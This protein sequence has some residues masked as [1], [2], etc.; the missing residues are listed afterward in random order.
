MKK[1]IIFGTGLL[2]VAGLSVVLFARK[3]LTP[4]QILL[5][6]NVE[7]LAQME[8]TGGGTV[9]AWSSETYYHDTTEGGFY[10]C[11]NKIDEVMWVSFDVTYEVT[12]CIGMGFTLC[13]PERRLVSKDI[14]WSNGC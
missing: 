6:R 12:N 9:R 11:P 2:L 14:G 3:P 4:E 10:P 7:A 1:M 8:N 5:K 13:T